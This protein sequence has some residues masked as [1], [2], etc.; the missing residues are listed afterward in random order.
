MFFSFLRGSCGVSLYCCGLVSLF[1]P[2]CKVIY[3]TCLGDPR[4][5]FLPV[6]SW[7]ILILLGNATYSFQFFGELYKI[8]A[9]GWSEFHRFFAV[10]GWNIFILM[11]G[12]GGVL[13]SCAMPIEFVLL[14]W[15]VGVRFPW[16]L[17][18][19]YFVRVN[20]SLSPSF[21]VEL[22]FFFVCL[23]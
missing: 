6:L 22:D 7:V 2:F 17:G 18:Y 1:F 20:V 9:D 10:F 4:Y 14:R 21:C 19:L 16:S 5:F 23:F 8:F 3:F 13:S 11:G 15:M 12:R